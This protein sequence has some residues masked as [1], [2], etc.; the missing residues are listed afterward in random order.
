MQWG[1]DQSQSVTVPLTVT[2]LSV[3]YAAAPWCA[4]SREEKIETASPRQRMIRS[5]RFTTLL[6]FPVGTRSTLASCAPPYTPNL[7]PVARTDC[8]GEQ[9]QLHLQFLRRNQP[10]CS[11]RKVSARSAKS[12]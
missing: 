12:T 6:H 7:N 3:S 4:T 11:A 5:L 9:D 10:Q 2:F 8:C 1:L